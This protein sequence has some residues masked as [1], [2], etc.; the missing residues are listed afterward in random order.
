MKARWF[1]Y[2]PD[3]DGVALFRTEADARRAFE[4]IVKDNREYW[5]DDN[6]MPDRF[7]QIC[8]GRIT[9]FADPKTADVVEVALE[10]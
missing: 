5:L 8:M 4:Q 10:Y 9:A 6:E 1:V 7:A 2:D 3:G